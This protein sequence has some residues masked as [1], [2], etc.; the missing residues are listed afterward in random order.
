MSEIRFC[1]TFAQLGVDFVGFACYVGLSFLVYVVYL[2]D[3]VPFAKHC[4]FCSLTVVI[5]LV[6]T[7]VMVACACLLTSCSACFPLHASAAATPSPVCSLPSSSSSSSSSKRSFATAF[8]VPAL[9]CCFQNGCRICFEGPSSSSCPAGPAHL[10][11]PALVSEPCSCFVTGCQRCFQA[12][13]PLE[14]NVH[15]EDADTGSESDCAED[16]RGRDYDSLPTLPF[17][18]LS[19][20][21][22][23]QGWDA[24]GMVLMVQECAE[25]CVA[26]TEYSVLSLGIYGLGADLCC[27]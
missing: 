3:S 16:D 7:V 14:G 17:D 8:V 10:P 25:Q 6:D 1:S 9:C 26:A 11:T 19:I 13:S 5:R 15:Q 27:R 12:V 22:G 4:C 2:S 20:K 24:G 23:R 18:N 21:A